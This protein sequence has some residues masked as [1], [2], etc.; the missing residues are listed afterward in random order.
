MNN[1]LDLRPKSPQVVFVCGCAG[2]LD[3]L[4]LL[5]PPTNAQALVV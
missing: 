5:D 2:L 3:M 4:D 1:L